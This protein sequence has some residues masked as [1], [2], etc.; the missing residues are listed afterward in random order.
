ML[1]LTECLGTN[2][3]DIDGARIGKL[4]DLAARGHTVGTRD[5][6]S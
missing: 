1:D 5:R 6:N 3:V 4:L 2:V